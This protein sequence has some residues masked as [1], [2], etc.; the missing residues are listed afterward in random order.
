MASLPLKSKQETPKVKADLTARYVFDLAGGQGYFQAAGAYVG[1]RWADLR[2]AEYKDTSPTTAV[3][4]GDPR[5]ILGSEAAYATFDVSLGLDKSG[6][7]YEIYINN[8]TDE[9]AQLDRYAECDAVKCGLNSTYIL[10]SHP[11]TIGIKFGE[12]F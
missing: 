5:A 1:Q 6:F 11:R 4:L 7:N 8:V 12:K 2:S 3:L 9:R 10:P